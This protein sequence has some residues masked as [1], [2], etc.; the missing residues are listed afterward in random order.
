MALAE[1]LPRLL[2]RE[3]R[4]AA[5][6]IRL[7]RRLFIDPGAAVIAINA[8]SR[9][10]DNRLAGSLRTARSSR[11]CRKHRIA[12]FVRRNRDQHS[13]GFGD[14]AVQFRR[15]DCCRLNTSALQLSGAIRVEDRR[16]L[17]AA[18]R[19]DDA[20]ETVAE[21][22][23]EMFRAIAKAETKRASA[24]AH[25]L[26]PPPIPRSLRIGFSCRDELAAQ[27]AQ[28]RAVEPAERPDGRATH[29]RRSIVKQPLGV[30]RK[31][32]HRRNCRS[33]SAHCGRN[34]HGRCV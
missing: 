20:V 10:I 24:S 32:P 29:Q 2:G 16:A 6:R 11:A 26:Q 5:R 23:D 25:S 1:V 18:N 9:K 27:C 28:P 22:F 21:N 17:G 13:I 7:G 4:A 12:I 31:I 3:P 15:H 8:D 19:A 33:R 14:R 30:M 34:D